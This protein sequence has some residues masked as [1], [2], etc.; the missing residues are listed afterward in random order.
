MKRIMVTVAAA[1]VIA[2][3]PAAQAPSNA[4]FEAIAALT[5]AKMHEYQVPGAAIGILENGVITTRGL[6]VTNVNDGMPVTGETVFPIASISK[7]FASR[8]QRRPGATTTPASV[9][10]GVSSKPS[11]ARRSIARSSSWCSDPSA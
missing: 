5:E 1:G 8:R 11:P 3:A 7:T 2:S 6:G 4:R 10:R 9:S